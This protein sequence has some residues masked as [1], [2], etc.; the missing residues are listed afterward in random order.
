MA[1]NGVS[2]PEQFREAARADREKRA[3]A[4]RLPSGLVARLV[5]PT[6]QE[7]LYFTGRLPQSL[8]A[9]ISPAKDQPPASREDIV[10]LARQLLEFT[11]FIF[12][13]PSVPEDLPPGI[14]I[15]IEDV[16]YALRWARGEVEN[17]KSKM[18]NGGLPTADRP[19]PTSP[20]EAPGSDLASFRGDRGGAEGAAPAGATG[21]SVRP[22][23]QWSPSKP[24]A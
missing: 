5:R 16:D 20:K 1:N 19:L 24:D 11:A 14:G 12:V 22:T 3:E 17:R 6:A 10:A 7:S 13:E 8:A 23:P 15:P 21:G 4:V 9:R 18:E 2:T